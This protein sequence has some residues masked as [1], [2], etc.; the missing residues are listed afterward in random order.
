MPRG[1]GESVAADDLAVAHLVD[2]HRLA[3]EVL[4]ALGPRR[5]PGQHDHVVVV[6]AQHLLGFGV[7]LVEVADDVRE[8]LPEALRPVIGAAPRH[9]LRRDELGIG[10]RDRRRLVDVATPE[11]IPCGLNYIDVVLRHSAS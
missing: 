11:G 8:Q 2:P 7:E 3:L 6:G 5:K 4:S 9:G 10:V 1:V